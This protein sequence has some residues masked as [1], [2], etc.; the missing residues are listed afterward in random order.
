MGTSH[1]GWFFMYGGETQ[2][3]N[4]HGISKATIAVP[5]IVFKGTKLKTLDKISLTQ[6]SL[7]DIFQS[8]FTINSITFSWSLTSLYILKLFTPHAKSE[9]WDSQSQN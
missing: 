2:P 1:G 9:P 5:T 7:I 3:N 6:Y 8:R 4:F